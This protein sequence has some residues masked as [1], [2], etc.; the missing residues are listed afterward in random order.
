MTA[1][2]DFEDVLGQPLDTFL[3]SSHN[4]MATALGSCVK[5]P[6]IKSSE[7]MSLILLEWNDDNS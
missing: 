1:L 3:L 7:I 5:W 2:H 4:I 6:L